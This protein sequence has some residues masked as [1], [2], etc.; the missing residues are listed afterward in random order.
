[1]MKSL[2]LAGL[3][4]IGAFYGA[5]LPTASA[6]TVIVLDEVII[7]ACEAEDEPASYVAASCGSVGR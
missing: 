3:F 1:M 7:L 4:T 6:R 2:V 5:T